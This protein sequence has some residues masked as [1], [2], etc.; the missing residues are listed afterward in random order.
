MREVFGWLSAMVL[1]PLAYWVGYQQGLSLQASIFVGIMVAVVLMWVFDLVDD[2]IPPLMGMSA[3][4]FFNLAPPVSRPF[5][6][7]L[8]EFIDAHGCV[9]LGHD[10]CVLRPKSAAGALPDAQVA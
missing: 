6:H 1:P 7:G 8:A 4:L 10:H 9:R 5:R 2:Y 3:A